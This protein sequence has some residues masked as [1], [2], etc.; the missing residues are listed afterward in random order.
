MACM[1][2]W[3]GQGGFMIEQDGY[4]VFI[5]PY[6]SDLVGKQEGMKRLVPA[7]MGAPDLA[8]ALVIATHDHIDHFDIDT[9]SAA[10]PHASVFA[11]PPSCL[12]HYREIGVP[13]EN[14]RKLA[15]GD[16][17]TWGPI[18]LG[19]VYARHTDDSIGVTLC[20][21]GVRAYFTADTLDSPQL[22]EA[23]R[24]C[25][26][27]FTCINGRLGNMNA[28]EAAK[29]SRDLSVRCA[30]PVHFGMFAGNTADPMD[31]VRALDGSGILTPVLAHAKPYELSALLGG[32][33]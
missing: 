9:L 33:S 15:V 27:I 4:R 8:G 24:G 10:D 3:V 12:E 28:A 22:R 14:L 11:G 32:A 16:V 31:F 17:L 2:T 25:D 18:K 6:F 5:D 29:L 20:A 19:G 7:P 26:I 21:E 1:L 13:Q 23:G 30:V